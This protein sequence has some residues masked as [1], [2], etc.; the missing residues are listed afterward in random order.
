MPCRTDRSPPREHNPRPIRPQRRTVDVTTSKPPA[1]KLALARISAPP[2]LTQSPCSR[3]LADWPM[4]TIANRQASQADRCHTTFA[5]LAHGRAD[6]S[7]APALC[8]QEL[9]A[10]RIVSRVKRSDWQLGF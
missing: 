5:H 7:N 6:K 2:F 3:A 9:V 10:K 1:R 4:M 8:I